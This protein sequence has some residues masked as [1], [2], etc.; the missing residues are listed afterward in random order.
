[1]GLLI[2]PPRKRRASLFGCVTIRREPS[3]KGREGPDNGAVDFV[4]IKETMAAVVNQA[5]ERLLLFVLSL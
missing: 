5:D 2:S 1:M 3:V 4:V